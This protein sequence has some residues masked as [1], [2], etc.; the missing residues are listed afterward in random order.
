MLVASP[1][2][3]A[4]LRQRLGDIV[5]PAFSRLSDS[6]RED[7]LALARSRDVLADY[8]R[9]VAQLR[10]NSARMQVEH[11]QVVAPLRAEVSSLQ[12]GA[13]ALRQQL[14]EQESE[15][16]R[17]SE[18]AEQNRELFLHAGGKELR[19]IPALNARPD[20]AQALAQLLVRHLQGWD[21]SSAWTPER[22]QLCQQRARSLGAER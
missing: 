13:S 7:R 14:D 22:L 11:E 16:A 6:T 15:I 18:I 19:Y 20:H 9:Q 8:E 5:T 3:R 10:D 12:Q 21:D 4:G 17:V 1:R 2:W